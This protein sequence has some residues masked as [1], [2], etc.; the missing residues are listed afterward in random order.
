MWRRENRLHPHPEPS[1]RGAGRGWAAGGRLR[2]RPWGGGANVGYR[3]CKLAEVFQKKGF[4]KRSTRLNLGPL[5]LGPIC[6]QAVV[7]EF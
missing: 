7:A 5:H 2:G 3:E 4:D 6:V 1:G